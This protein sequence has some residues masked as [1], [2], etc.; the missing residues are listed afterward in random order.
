MQLGFNKS[1]I[2]ALRRLERRFPRKDMF[3]LFAYIILSS[4]NFKQGVVCGQATSIE[5]SNALGGPGYDYA[6]DIIQSTDGG[7]LIVANSAE[8]GG[9]VTD[10]YGGAVDI[11]LT[12]L[13]SLGNLVWQKNYGGSSI[14]QSHVGIA[15]ADGGYIIVGYSGSMDHDVSFNH[16]LTDAW[17][18]NVESGGNL[19]WE[20][21]YGG[22]KSEQGWGICETHDG[23]FVFVGYSHSNDGDVTSHHGTY[24]TSD[25]WIVKIDTLGNIIW[26]KS[27]GSTD[28][29]YAHGV[30][31]LFNGDLV[32]GGVAEWGN[33]DVVG[34]HGGIGIQDGWV[35]TLDSVGDLKWSKAYGGYSYDVIWD[36]TQAADSTIHCIG[37]TQSF[38]GDIADHK[39]TPADYFKDDCLYLRLDTLGNLLLEKCFGG[40]GGDAGYVIIQTIDNGEILACCASSTDLDVFGHHGDESLYDY[41]IVKLDSDAEIEWSIST[42]GNASDECFSLLQSQDSGF[43]AVGFT[44]SIDGDVLDHYPGPS[45]WDSWVVKL[46]KTCPGIW[47]YADTDTDGYGDALNAQ[48]FCS[49]MIG[50]VLDSTD[51]NDADFSVFPGASET[52]NTI[53][54]NCNGLIDEGLPIYTLYADLDLDGFGNDTISITSC[55]DSIF[56]YISDSTDCFDLDA[57]IYPGAIEI[58]NFLD[59]DCNGVID[60][61]ITYIHAFQDADNDTYGNSEIDSLACELPYGYVADSTDC[62]DTD[63]TMYPG[64]TELLNGVDDNCDGQ[65]DEELAIVTNNLNTYIIYPNPTID[66]IHLICDGCNS[67]E[68]LNIFLFNTENQ[69]VLQMTNILLPTEIDMQKLPAGPYVL[70]LRSSTSLVTQL[71][72]IKVSQ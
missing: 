28:D 54:D 14:E 47:Y 43:V 3:K 64:A 16:G 25:Y 20:N 8:V 72:I 2:S 57:L 69:I 38:D 30:R 39:G 5:W 12:K 13:D 31:E 21:S 45:N 63:P 19:E 58:C 4:F 68:M 41:W 46:N 42:G 60:D 33:G 51:C 56:G 23:N 7:Y 55:L 26:Q 10:F 11:W 18:F 37:Q 71:H 17:V 53:D 9:D 52:C 65:I 29:D 6:K 24:E 59:D 22:T 50:Y 70:E 1:L 67:N 62:N 34:F 15:T 66:I 49:E 36:I 27:Y 44:N 40:T 61:N 32:V 35:V 48:L